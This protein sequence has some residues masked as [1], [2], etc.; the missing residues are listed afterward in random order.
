MRKRAVL[1]KVAPESYKDFLDAVE[2]S[3]KQ[4]EKL[5]SQELEG[6]KPEAEVRWQAYKLMNGLGFHYGA[7]LTRAYTEHIRPDDPDLAG[8]IDGV[9]DDLVMS[10]NDIEASRQMRDDSVIRRAMDELP[11]LVPSWV[12]RDEMIAEALASYDGKGV[13]FNDFYYSVLQA[14]NDY[15]QAFR[16]FLLNDKRTEKMAFR[17][18]GS[19]GEF[20][21]QSLLDLDEDEERALLKNVIRSANT[22]VAERGFYGIRQEPLPPTGDFTVLFWRNGPADWKVDNRTGNAMIARDNGLE[23]IKLDSNMIL[24]P[25]HQALVEKVVDALDDLPLYTYSIEAKERGEYPEP[26]DRNVKGAIRSM[27]EQSN[28]EVDREEISLMVIQMF[29]VFQRAKRHDP[30]AQAQVASYLSLTSAWLPY[31]RLIEEWMESR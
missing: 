18:E 7:A 5:G 17:K 14:I 24:V 19:G 4:L 25:F 2:E 9:M 12:D 15:M 31:L 10:Y 29:E 20:I 3:S 1:G 22:K 16:M 30:V 6:L 28:L 11:H 23:S 13:Y 27:L 8:T 26:T 21:P